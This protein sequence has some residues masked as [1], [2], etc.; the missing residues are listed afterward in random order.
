VCRDRSAKALRHPK[1]RVS[2]QSRTRNI[3]TKTSKAKNQTRKKQNPSRIQ[4][5]KNQKQEKSKARKIK[6]KKNQKHKGKSRALPGGQ[7][8]R[9]SLRVAF[10]N[11]QIPAKKATAAGG[12]F[13]PAAKPLGEGSH[14]PRTENAE[15]AQAREIVTKNEQRERPLRGLPPGRGQLHGG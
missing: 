7:P 14:N 5:K 3:K 15:A 4:R 9:L 2:L 6:S 10:W 12:S 11:C 13:T 1:A 8:R